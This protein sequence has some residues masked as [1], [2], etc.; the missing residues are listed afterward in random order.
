M[1][2]G[3]PRPRLV[4]LRPLLPA[5]VRALQSAPARRRE[6]RAAGSAP[7]G[8]SG[9]GAAS[10]SL[11]GLASRVLRF[12][13]RCRAPASA[14]PASPPPGLP[15][16][17]EPSRAPASPAAVRLVESV[18]MPLAPA[19]G[20]VA[21]LLPVRLALHGLEPLLAVA[22]RLASRTGV[23]ARH[24]PALRR[25]PGGPAAPS[26]RRARPPLSPRAIAAAAGNASARGRTAPAAAPAARLRAGAEPL[27]RPLPSRPSARPRPPRRPLRSWQ[28]RSRP[29]S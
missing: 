1:R 26:R 4:R 12:L 7:A 3:L 14:S 17:F 13:R 22:G 6:V 5:V 18:V 2:R 27:T 11:V 28:P 20:E 19:G 21:R 8:R 23:R 29:P 15:L 24:R 9:C 10:A 16:P 25:R